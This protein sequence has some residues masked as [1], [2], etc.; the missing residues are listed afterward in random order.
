MTSDL[1]ISPPK[2]IGDHPM[3]A[4]YRSTYPYEKPKENNTNGESSL[5]Q[6][7]IYIEQF[8]SDVFGLT[9]GDN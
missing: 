5:K 1:K 6:Q 7:G 3:I 8:K 2:N 4:R 9:F